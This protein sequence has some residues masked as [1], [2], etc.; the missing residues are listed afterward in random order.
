MHGSYGYLHTIR[1]RAKRRGWQTDGTPVYTGVPSVCHLGV[2]SG[3]RISSPSRSTQATQATAH[4]IFV[5]THTN[6]E[7]VPNL[8]QAH[9]K[10][11]P[12]MSQIL[13]IL[14]MIRVSSWNR[15]PTGQS[16]PE[17]TRCTDGVVFHTQLGMSIEGANE[18]KKFCRRCSGAARHR[19]IW[20]LVIETP[21][22]C[23]L[24]LVSK[25]QKG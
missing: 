17:S 22:V 2:S 16:V 23:T 5:L 14:H 8:P 21:F 12:N 4:I 3:W 11:I 18:V 24:T 20:A 10:Q 15:E 6:P 1:V 25:M 9:T 19:A 7:H 13:C